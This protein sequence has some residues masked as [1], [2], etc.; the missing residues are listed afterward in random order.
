[1]ALCYDDVYYGI[2][3][4]YAYA[5]PPWR[6]SQSRS[7]PAGGQAEVIV[8]AARIRRLQRARPRTHGMADRAHSEIVQPT[9]AQRAAL[10]ELRAPSA[11]ASTSSS[12]LPEGLPSIPTG[13]LAARRAGSRSCCRRCRPCAPALEQFYQSLDDEQKADS[14]PSRRE[15]CRRRKIGAISRRSATSARRRDRPADRADRP[16]RA[17]DG[18]AAGGP[19]RAEGRL[20]QGRRWLK[21]NCPSYQAL[22]R[23]PGQAMEKRLTAML[24]AV[25]TVQPA[26]AKFYD[27]LTTT[28]GALQH[29]AL[30]G[31]PVG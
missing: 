21:A 2:I 6:S 25:K 26:L 12:R 14:T 20:R 11:K 23:R 22:T 3:R 31:K 30:D 5:T 18:R 13:R 8:R 7:A 9:D 10:D 4:N 28:E 17:A 19:R 29:A 24:A 27:A 15:R 16:G 1:L